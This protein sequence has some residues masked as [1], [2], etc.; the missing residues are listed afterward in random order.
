MLILLIELWTWRL[1]RDIGI[2]FLAGLLVASSPMGFMNAV[3]GMETTTFTLALMGTFAIYSFYGLQKPILLGLT[4]GLSVLL[5]PEGLIALAIPFF[6][7]IRDVIE[8]R[9]LHAKKYLSLLVAFC[10]LVVPYLFAVKTTTGN[11]LPTTY[12]GKIISTDPFIHEKL[13]LDI[14]WGF[15]F[16]F[17]GHWRTFAQWGI[18]GIFVWTIMAIETAFLIIMTLSHSAR[19]TSNQEKPTKIKNTMLLLLLSVVAVVVSAIFSPPSLLKI[20]L[21]VTGVFVLVFWVVLLNL[22]RKSNIPAVTISQLSSNTLPLVFVLFM[23]FAYGAL[24][25]AGPIFGGYYNRYIMPLL[26]AS[27]VLFSLGLVTLFSYF[28]VKPKVKVICLFF[29]VSYPLLVTSV[30]LAY[31]KAVCERECA[32]NSGI[33]YQAGEWLKSNTPH[34]AIIFT[35]Y[36][37]LGVVGFYADRRILD[38]GALINP[39]IFA[40]YEDV[41]ARGMMRWQRTIKYMCDKKVD[42]FVT[43]PGIEN[44]PTSD[45]TGFVGFELVASFTAPNADSPLKAITIWKIDREKIKVSGA[46]AK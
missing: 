44:E 26:P 3:S 2:T 30:R 8:R 13:V 42:Y 39:D 7:L 24:F 35:G 32:L 12:R 4:S 5:R 46:L 28:R 40:Y 19:D 25:R 20:P 36:T 21:A 29:L 23:P 1:T 10:I 16:L 38:M 11:W 34:G 45:P 14:L 17:K 43:A 22:L 18:A 37:G 6:N 33:R 31:H 15:I 9:K 27:V 41:P